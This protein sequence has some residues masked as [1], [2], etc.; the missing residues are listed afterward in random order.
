MWQDN[1]VIDEIYVYTLQVTRGF[2]RAL[3]FYPLYLRFFA[4]TGDAARAV[5]AKNVVPPLLI[6]AALYP[7][8]T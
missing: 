2:L 5:C 7:S 8:M 4:D 6:S 1:G 3:V